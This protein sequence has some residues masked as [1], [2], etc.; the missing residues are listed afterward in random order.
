MRGTGEKGV[1]GGKWKSKEGKGWAG[2][3]RVRRGWEWMGG[4]GREW[5]E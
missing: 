4:K 5:E 2:M 3:G 1:G